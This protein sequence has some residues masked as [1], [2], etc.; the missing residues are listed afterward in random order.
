MVVWPE[1]FSSATYLPSCDATIY[2]PLPPVHSF[3]PLESWITQIWTTPTPPGGAS[4]TTARSAAK[5]HATTLG[6][7]PWR[8]A[9][10]TVPICVTFFRGCPTAPVCSMPGPVTSRDSVL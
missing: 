3:L 5:L 7:P 1:P 6:P 4:Y 10:L 8:L 2:P 9:A